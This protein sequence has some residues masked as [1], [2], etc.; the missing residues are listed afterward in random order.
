MLLFVFVSEISKLTV[1]VEN[2]EHELIE[3]GTENTKDTGTKKGK[4][5]GHGSYTTRYA[6]TQDKQ[7]CRGSHSPWLLKLCEVTENY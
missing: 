5:M 1:S 2:S 6:N 4:P 7:L 3:Q